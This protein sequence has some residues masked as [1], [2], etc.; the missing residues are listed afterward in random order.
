M[1]DQQKPYRVTEKNGWSYVVGEPTP[2][3]SGPWRYRWE[4]EE[5]AS[6]CNARALGEGAPKEG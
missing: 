1:T 4:A 5:Y 3:D 2:K 6:E